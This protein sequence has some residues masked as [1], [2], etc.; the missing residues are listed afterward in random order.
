MARGLK[1]HAA[2]WLGVAVCLAAT[3]GAVVVLQ[4]WAGRQQDGCI[5]SRT[6]VSLCRLAGQFMAAL[7]SAAAATAPATGTSSNAPVCWHDSGVVRTDHAVSACAGIVR[8]WESHVQAAYVQPYIFTRLL[9]QLLL[10]VQLVPVCS[11]GWSIF[12][13]QT[14]LHVS[15]MLTGTQNSSRQ[16]V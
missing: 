6:G 10:A 11:A 13:V 1:F 16:H 9:V 2:C 4:W 8:C 7:S 14:P 15:H 12:V 3:Y 5:C